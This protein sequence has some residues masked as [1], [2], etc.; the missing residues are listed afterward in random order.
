MQR[1]KKNKYI[2]VFTLASLFL[3]SILAINVTRP[4]ASDSRIKTV[5]F[6][7]DNVVPIE[8]SVFTTTQL[9]FNQNEI[10][11]NIQNGDLDAWIINVQKGLGNMVFIKPTIVNSNTNMTIVTNQHT[12]YFH[13]MSQSRTD[14]EHNQP[15]YAI[16]FIYPKDSLIFL[17]GSRCHDVLLSSQSVE[18]DEVAESEKSIIVSL[19][20]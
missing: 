4:N 9:V 3:P 12:Y 19:K 14:L 18:N 6:Q 8:A 16:K 7:K 20:H 11:E 2:V 13:L 5:S 10:I 17:T 1:A 15:T